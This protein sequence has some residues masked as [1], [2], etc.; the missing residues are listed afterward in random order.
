MKKIISIVLSVLM[1]AGCFVA[2]IP[3]TTANNETIK[4]PGAVPSVTKGELIYSEDFEGSDLSDAEGT[5]LTNGDL[6][7]AL[8]W[9]ATFVTDDFMTVVAEESDHAV[10]IGAVTSASMELTFLNDSRIAGGD[11]IVEYTHTMVDNV[12]GINR[13]FGVVTGGDASTNACTDTVI[14]AMVEER[15]QTAVEIGFPGQK[16]AKQTTEFYDFATEKVTYT[17]RTGKNV[18]RAKGTGSVYGMEIRFRLVIDNEFGVSLWM[19]GAEDTATLVAYAD[20]QAKIGS[21]NWNKQATAIASNVMFSILKGYTVKVDD[22]AV[23]AIQRDTPKMDGFS[24]FETP[25]LIVSEVMAQGGEGH[26]WIEIYN[27]GETGLNIY[28][29]AVAREEG[30]AINNLY[31]GAVSEEEICYVLPGANETYT[32]P[33]YADGVLLPGDAVVLLIPGAGAS[34]DSFKEN[35]LKQ[36][37]GMSDE[38]IAKLRIFTAYGITINEKGNDLFAVTPIDKATGTAKV[39]GH[40]ITDHN[41]VVSLTADFK[42]GSSSF[43]SFDGVGCFGYTSE[44]YLSNEITF[45]GADGKYTGHGLV[46]AELRPAKKEL[47]GVPCTPGYLP[48]KNAKALHMVT[49][50]GMLFEEDMVEQIYLNIEYIP[51]ITPEST[52]TKKFAGWMDEAGNIVQ[53][54]AAVRTKGED[55]VLV[56]VYEDEI[57]EFAGYQVTEAVG[58]KYDLRIVASVDRLDSV[59]FGMKINFKYHNG[60]KNVYGSNEYYCRFVYEEISTDYGTGTVSASTYDANYLVAFHIE[61]CPVGVPVEYTV[62]TFAV[63]EDETGLRTTEWSNT[64]MTFSIAG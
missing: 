36:T 27:A 11:Y 50:T 21:I 38:A 22:I 31:S 8:G 64:P 10:E 47:E 32:N 55:R 17:T 24:K 12:G 13:A 14:S 56:A 33:A 26:E 16:S 3:T 51:S 54:L 45:L 29:F 60:V 7:S 59:A 34:V 43:G 40:N 37:Y 28:D 1:L 2:L 52:L 19:V 30:I 63:F 9:S 39:L 48:S 58:G 62:I 42:A 41:Y 20:M 4:N 25:G 61:G 15:A 53:S 35:D 49:L 46:D 18:T 5:P 44:Q 57:P 6:A 23:Y